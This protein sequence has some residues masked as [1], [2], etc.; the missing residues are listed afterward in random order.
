MCYN[1]YKACV[2]QSLGLSIP[3]ALYFRPHTTY[4]TIQSR[5]FLFTRT[6]LHVHSPIGWFFSLTCN[7]QPGLVGSTVTQCDA[8]T[9]RT[10]II[11]EKEWSQI[12]P[13]MEVRI[14]PKWRKLLC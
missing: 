1:H 8:F 2:P 6:A 7:C 13:Y 10:D 14:N 12:D 3:V 5:K 4:I 11:F 9:S